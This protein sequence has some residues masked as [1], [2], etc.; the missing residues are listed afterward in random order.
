MGKCPEG[1]L[2]EERVSTVP[3][4][5]RG[6][7]WILDAEEKANC[8]ANAFKAQTIMI[9]AAVNEYSEIPYVHPTF[10]CGMPTIEATVLALKTFDD[11]T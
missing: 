9:D 4:F 11:P 7:E 2:Q 1:H 10:F 8:F 5:K 3:A 6:T